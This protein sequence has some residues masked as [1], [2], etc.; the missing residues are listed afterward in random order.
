MNKCH[1]YIEQ[2][3]T[4]QKVNDLLSKIRPEELQDDL[5]QEMALALLSLN[6]KKILDLNKRGK[7][8]Q[9]ALGTIWTMGTMTK[10]NF[11]KTYKKNDFEKA[12]EYLRLQ[13]GNEIP[14]KASVIAKNLLKEKLEKNPND[15]HESIIFNK[16]VEL[17]SC[18][19][20]ADYFMIP[21]LHVF[22]VVKKTKEELKKEI[23]KKL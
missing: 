11:Y 4:S 1:K 15:A 19:K 17:R 16:Y 12:L 7:L 22:N 13:L 23:N 20:V 2:I 6:C 21:H 8:L 10:G 3:Y 9:Y 14:I 5:K 18:K